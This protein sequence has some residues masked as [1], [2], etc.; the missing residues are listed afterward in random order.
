M[1][2][3]LSPIECA[4]VSGL[5]GFFAWLFIMYVL[6]IMNFRN[7][8]RKDSDRRKLSEHP[9]LLSQQIEYQNKTTYRA[10][11]FYLKVL[12][13]VLGGIGYVVLFKSPLSES[14]RLFVDA[15]G[16]IIVLVSG[17]FCTMV[18]V[19]QKSK[20]ERWLF[21]YR[22]WS[23]L[24]WNETWFFVTGVIILASTRPFVV[25]LLKQTAND[26]ASVS[27]TIPARVLDCKML[28][29]A[30]AMNLCKILSDAFWFWL[31]QAGLGLFWIFALFQSWKKGRR[32]G[33][34]VQIKRGDQSMQYFL[35]I[36]GLIIG[37]PVAICA[38]VDV[39][40]V[41]GH[42]V[43]WILFD[44]VLVANVCL[45]NAWFRNDVLLPFVNRLSE[46]ENR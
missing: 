28:Q 32:G 15:A 34:E 7:G 6:C 1:I 17:L 12:L 27:S 18:L 26:P 39:P 37:I 11:E 14:A 38:S 40:F 16:W 5:I 43:L 13:A 35:V 2:T 24:F 20:I 3:R 4:V 19:H 44:S 45:R 9:E 25:L 46:L 33:P 29:I 21:G 41:T 10:L 8:V 30:T 31:L 22:L 36:C 42:R 23:P